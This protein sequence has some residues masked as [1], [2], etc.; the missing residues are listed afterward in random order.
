MA[1]PLVELINGNPEGVWLQTVRVWAKAV[2]KKLSCEEA[3]DDED[4]E[5]CFEREV[6]L[7]V[8]YGKDEGK[9]S[10][11]KSCAA[12]KELLDFKVAFKNSNG[13]FDIYR[14]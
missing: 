9:L 3:F 4:K 8:T 14:D 1:Y 11:C 13:T 5:D 6:Y 10:V 7:G 12:K 2:A